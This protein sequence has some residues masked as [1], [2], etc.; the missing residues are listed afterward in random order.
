MDPTSSSKRA[1]AGAPFVVLAAVL[2][3][4]GCGRGAA[5]EFER[6]PVPVTVV[7]AVS[8]DV[9]I[10]LDA[11]GKTTAREVV[12]IQPQIS[13]SIIAIHF[14]DG[15]DVKKGDLLFTIDT[16]PFE[17]SL[18]QARANLAKSKAEKVQAEA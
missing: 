9:P 14:K 5:Q 7:V 4:T 12:S 18:Q 8:Q 17:A 15:A 3:L 10:Y 1:T 16:R 13:G 2:V 11:I 6:P